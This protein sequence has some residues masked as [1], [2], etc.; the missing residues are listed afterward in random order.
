M[1]NCCAVRVR[2][3]PYTD[4]MNQPQPAGKEIGKRLDLFGRFQ[5]KDFTAKFRDLT[6][7]GK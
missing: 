7:G 2:F 5:A 6:G 4:D 1:R 3:P